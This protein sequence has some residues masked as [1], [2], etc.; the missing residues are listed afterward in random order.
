MSKNN[1]FL[2]FATQRV[3]VGILAAI[4]VLFLISMTISFLT[5]SSSERTSQSVARDEKLIETTGQQAE[6][7]VARETTVRDSGQT[8]EE[9][10]SAWRKQ[11]DSMQGT[12]EME[13]HKLPSGTEK[14]SREKEVTGDT[15][16]APERHPDAAHPKGVILVNAIIDPMVYELK[17]RFWGWRPNDLIKFTDNVNNYQLGVLEVARRT[18]MILSDSISRTGSAASLDLN[19]EEAINCFMIRADK[20]WF[21]SAES[22]YKQGIREL[23]IYKNKLMLGQAGFYTRS[24]NLIPLL[25]TL[26]QLLGSC[27][28]NLVKK[29]EE[30]GDEVSW[31]KA[32]D[33]FYY[34]RGVA[35][36][37]MS[38]LKA[39]QIDFHRVIVSR[40][41]EESLH[42]AIISCEKA[43]SLK[44]WIVLESSL[45]GILANHRANMATSISHARFYLDVL[46]ETLST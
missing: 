7:Q 26:Q 42:H 44:P 12:S 24:D 27:D 3:V 33:Y 35:H 21:P 17:D 31:F 23:E 19:L 10:P 9:G 22:K 2:G 36:A 45:S 32:D 1:G 25:D 6:K 38:I 14:D 18:T 34:S 4:V 5:R 28:Q 20:F 39:I 30:N 46:Q 41:G 13:N 43:A 11:F 16:E 15:A 37:M 29:H 40:N 8:A